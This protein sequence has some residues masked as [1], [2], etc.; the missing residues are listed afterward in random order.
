M[1]IVFG[2]VYFLNLNQ[3]KQGINPE[4]LRPT[5]GVYYTG[6]VFD[7]ERNFCVRKST[8][9]IPGIEP[10]EFKTIQQ[11]EDVN[12]V[13]IDTN[14]DAIPLCTGE[15]NQ[16]DKDA[17]PSLAKNVWNTCLF[18]FALAK[19]DL[20]LC[21]SIVTFFPNDREYQKE[22]CMK[23]VAIILGNKAVCE[24]ITDPG[25]KSQCLNN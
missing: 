6:F 1:I 20:G 25:I 17:S 14:L 9:N 15:A 16:I 13:N 8:L 12:N 3:N 10:F 2:A 7:S 21:D 23:E 19:R 18:D 22:D 11:C 24:R 4:S 5:D